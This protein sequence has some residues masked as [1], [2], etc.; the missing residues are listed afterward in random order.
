MLGHEKN[1]FKG[2]LVY[3]QSATDVR[4]VTEQISFFVLVRKHRFVNKINKS[5]VVVSLFEAYSEKI[6]RNHIC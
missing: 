5:I 1:A 2:F 6:I 4:K 3:G